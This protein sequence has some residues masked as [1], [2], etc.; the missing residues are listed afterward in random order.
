MP[1]IC[2]VSEWR[3]FKS[4]RCPLIQEVIALALN[5]VVGL[6]TDLVFDVRQF[7][8]LLIQI[9]LNL[10]VVKLRFVIILA[11]DFT[12][13]HVPVHLHFGNF[14]IVYVRLVML[15]IFPFL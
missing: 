5:V 6:L 15:S 4:R 13:L 9:L 10:V 3:S 11:N 7:G 14:F 1:L 2:R 8:L 12:T